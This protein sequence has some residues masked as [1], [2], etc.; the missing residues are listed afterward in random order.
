MTLRSKVLAIAST[1]ILLTTPVLSDSKEKAWNWASDTQTS[2]YIYQTQSLGV[3]NIVPRVINSVVTITTMKSVVPEEVKP[4]AT[5]N[6]P[7]EE[8]GTLDDFLEDSKFTPAETM[9]PQD[10]RKEKFEAA[11]FGTGFF[12]GKNLIVTN[13]HVIDGGVQDEYLVSIHSKKWYAY[14][15][16]L[17]SADDKTDIAILEIINPDRDIETIV[18]LQ[19]ARTLPRVGEPLFAIGHPHGLLWTVTHALQVLLIENLT[20]F[21]RTWCKQIHQLIRVIV[22]VHCLT[23][24]A[25]LWVLTL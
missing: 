12:I 5:P 2:T 25:R 14:K 1:A 20:T 10:P 21:G 3:E 15:A 17:V 24:V 4:V 22:V 7:K 9:E 18:P 6:S 11:G 23:C 13:H 16:H 8:N 19:L